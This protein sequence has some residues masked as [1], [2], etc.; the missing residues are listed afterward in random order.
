MNKD[1]TQIQYDHF[2]VKK[3]ML[4]LYRKHYNPQRNLSARPIYNE[5]PEGFYFNIFFHQIVPPP[6]KQT[7]E[8]ILRHIPNIKAL[9]MNP[10]IYNRHWV[11]IKYNHQIKCVHLNNDTIERIKTKQVLLPDY[12][13]I[14]REKTKWQSHPDYD[15]HEG[16]SQPI[17]EEYIQLQLTPKKGGETT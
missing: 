13:E 1:I 17:E 16:F 14:E 6:Y 3:L 5:Q 7:Q 8:T 9:I 2:G 12:L 10:K 11:W 4:D 15:P